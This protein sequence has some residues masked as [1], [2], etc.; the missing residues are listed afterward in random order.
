MNQGPFFSKLSL[1]VSVVALLASI[2]SVAISRGVARSTGTAVEAIQL[3]SDQL[4]SS[5]ETRRTAEALRQLAD[6]VEQQTNQMQADASS[7]ST[8][9]APTIEP[10]DW[11]WKQIQKG[12]NAKAVRDTLGIPPFI[13]EDRHTR[14]YWYFNGSV[15]F[16]RANGA[17][18]VA[19]HAWPHRTFATHDQ[20]SSAMKSG[21]TRVFS[22]SIDG[23]Q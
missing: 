4:R 23:N 8:Q 15:T 2:Y 10:G 5:Q 18:A 12:M 9:S 20:F 19:S 3:L 22:E 14:T 6:R 7:P 13:S 21:N 1:V 17:W 16:D 11:E